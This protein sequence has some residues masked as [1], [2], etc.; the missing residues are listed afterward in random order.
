MCNNSILLGYSCPFTAIHWIKVGQLVVE[1]TPQ[2][3]HTRYDEARQSLILIYTL[4]SIAMAKAVG[5]FLYFRLSTRPCEKIGFFKRFDF[6]KE[7][8]L[9]PEKFFYCMHT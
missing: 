7:R 4:N 1:V 2:I 6:Q 3:R 8:L 5:K 9:M